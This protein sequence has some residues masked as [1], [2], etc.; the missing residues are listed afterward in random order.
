MNT[1]ILALRGCVRLLISVI[2]RQQI[3]VIL[4]HWHGSLLQQ[5]QETNIGAR[6]AVVELIEMKGSESVSHLGGE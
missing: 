2:V 5:H 1:L 4:S 6:E 3:C